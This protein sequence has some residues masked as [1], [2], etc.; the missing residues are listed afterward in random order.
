MSEIPEGI[1]KIAA[2]TLDNVLCH[3]HE[4]YDGSFERT[5]Q[6]AISEIARA[7][8]AERERCADLAMK[9]ADGCGDAVRTID[10]CEFQTELQVNN[11][12][13][14]AGG[15]RAARSIAHAIRLPSPPSKEGE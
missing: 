6:A 12:R 7:I 2:D 4:A 8:L 3:D 13:Y 14:Y 10:S 11:R 9:E 5:R 1:A 15:N